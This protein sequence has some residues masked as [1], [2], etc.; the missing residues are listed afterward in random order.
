MSS[1]DKHSNAKR[2]RRKILNT[3]EIKFKNDVDYGLITRKTIINEMIEQLKIEI[4]CLRTINKT[5]SNYTYKYIYALTFWD[6]F[7]ASK[8]FETELN[9]NGNKVKL[10]DYNKERVYMQTNTYKILKMENLQNLETVKNFLIDK[11]GVTEGDN[12]SEYAEEVKVTK[13]EH[14]KYVDPDFPA[15]KFPNVKLDT[16]N[17]I[18]AIK[19]LYSMILGAIM[20]SMDKDLKLFNMELIKGNALDVEKQLT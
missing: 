10:E 8:L 2:E 4:Q 12:E 16:G 11:L 1:R 9:F 6:P 5:A 3:I 13:L 18:M 14:E 19:K 15:D 20:K 7:D 17:I